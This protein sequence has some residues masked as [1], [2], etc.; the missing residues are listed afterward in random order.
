MSLII[1]I[2]ER[3]D[4]SDSGKKIGVIYSEIEK[5]VINSGGIPIGINNDNIDLYMDIC[6]GFIFQGGDLVDELN[7]DIIRR[8]YDMDIPTLGI[9]LG[10]QEMAIF[11]G[12]KLSLIDNHHIDGCHSIRIKNGSLLKE[13]IESDMIDV[14]SR[15]HFAV[16]SSRFDVVGYADDLVVEAIEDKSKKFFMGLQWHPED[17]YNKYQDIKKI[18][19]YFIKMCND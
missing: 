15:H 12:G 14:N 13:I 7:I 4:F 11:G 8:L 16:E 9:C 6:N 17:M 2:I 18:F 1:G 19:D 3:N 10:M 5:C